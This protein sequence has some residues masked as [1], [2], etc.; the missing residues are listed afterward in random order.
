M[1][2]VVTLAVGWNWWNGRALP[3][4]IAPV[5]IDASAAPAPSVTAASGS[6]SGDVVVDVGGD[7]RHPGLVTLPVGSRV[8]DAIEEAGGA[9]GSTAGVNLARVLVDGEQ[10]VVGRAAAS[11]GQ[12]GKVPV[13]TADAGAL[14]ALP[15]IGPVLAQRIV[16]WR[17]ANGPFSSVD[18]LGDVPGIGPSLLAKLKPLVTT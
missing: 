18:A 14:D 13:N 2:A 12:P 16:D 3:E 17:T 7:V 5:S 8:A 15:G 1:I 9:T 4:Q 6:S 11:S 10:I